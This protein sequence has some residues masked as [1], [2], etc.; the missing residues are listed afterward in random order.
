MGYAAD[1]T[2]K[3]KNGDVI[4]RLLKTFSKEM[5]AA[6]SKATTS[7]KSP[8]E[9][10]GEAMA[11]MKANALKLVEKAVRGKKNPGKPDDSLEGAAAKE[12]RKKRQQQKERVQKRKEE[13][14]KKKEDER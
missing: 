2:S 7:E 8:E 11:S 12:A 4:G 9:I 3:N 14:Q 5:E 10:H 6:L 1:L 13:K